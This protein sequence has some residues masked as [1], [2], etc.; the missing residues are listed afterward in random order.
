VII[1]F[2]LVMDV[3]HIK[4]LFMKKVI[5][6]SSILLMI[7]FISSGFHQNRIK[8]KDDNLVN[9]YFSSE[10][11]KELSIILNFVDSHILEGKVEDTKLLNSF[12][13]KWRESVKKVVSKGACCNTIFTVKEELD[14]LENISPELFNKIFR[15]GFWVYNNDSTDS[16]QVIH[17]RIRETDLFS[18]IADMAQ[19]KDYIKEYYDNVRSAGDQ[20][21]SLSSFFYYKSNYN[22]DFN[23]DR[24]RLVLALDLFVINIKQ[25][26]YNE[27][28]LLKKR[29]EEIVW[30][31]QKK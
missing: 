7:F 16:R 10:E 12:K 20:K 19:S 1:D 26:N 28:P 29:F 13:R 31:K 23:L 8:L 17:N 11:I 6:F 9:K 14:V 2:L 5:T 25:L 4:L 3:L 18:L 30:S 21:P 27:N 24:V 15:F 22:Y